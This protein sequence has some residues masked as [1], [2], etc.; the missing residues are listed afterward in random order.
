MLDIQKADWNRDEKRQTQT[1]MSLCQ[2][3]GSTVEPYKK[4]P[5]PPTSIALQF[6][7]RNY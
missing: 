6:V 4:M 7:S 1:E 3:E 2:T 5:I